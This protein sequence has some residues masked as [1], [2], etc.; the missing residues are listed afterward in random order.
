[1]RIVKKVFALCL[2]LIIFIS[3]SPAKSLADE[4]ITVCPKGYT[5]TIP[6][7]KLK[8]QNIKITG[9]Y[10]LKINK[11]KF[12]KGLNFKYSWYVGGKK[13]SAKN[14]IHLTKI[15]IGLSYYAKIKSVS[16]QYSTNVKVKSKKY[17]LLPK[18]K[19]KKG[20]IICIDKNTKVRKLFY[21]KNGAIQQ[22]LQ[23]RFGC[24]SSPTRNGFFKIFLKKIDE[25]S[26]E[27]KTAMPYAMYF[28]GGQAIHYSSDFAARGYN[29]CSHGCVNIKYKKG[30]AKLFKR[31]KVGTKVY[32]Y[33]S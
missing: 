22:T 17:F 9:K 8:K 32:V 28:N 18:N 12:P 10:S 33:K 16:K 5:G 15:K 11:S 31:V 1:V 24:S 3:I 2:F 21:V 23:A 29:G 19:C 25:V 26:D 6:N 30:I 7:C 13:K 20:K 4:P 27:Y 14:K